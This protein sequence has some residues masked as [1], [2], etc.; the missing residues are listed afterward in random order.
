MEFNVNFLH[1]LPENNN[2]AINYI[3]ITYLEIMFFFNSLD[4]SFK[5][6]EYKTSIIIIFEPNKIINQKL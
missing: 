1:I 5:N 3:F 2:K 6:N 4:R